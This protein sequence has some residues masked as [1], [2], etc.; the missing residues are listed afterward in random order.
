[1]QT[2]KLADSNDF[3]IAVALESKAYR[4]HMAWNDTAGHWSMDLRDEN[5]RDLVRHVAVV[6][7]FPLFLQ[8]HRHSGVPRGEL[9]AVVAN[10]SA[11]KNQAIG[12]DGFSSG[13]FV[14]VYIPE[15]EKNALI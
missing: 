4:L 2:I 8:Y 3:V 6:P 7:N 1:M 10:T 9:M 13:K 12:R 5:D 14:M 11:A 15:V